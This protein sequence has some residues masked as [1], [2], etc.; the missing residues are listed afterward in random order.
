MASCFL[1]SKAVK[2]NG[3]VFPSRRG[4]EMFKRG[5]LFGLKEHISK[6]A[7]SNPNKWCPEGEDDEAVSKPCN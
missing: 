2:T 5:R 1:F 6:S 3:S 4:G 7:T